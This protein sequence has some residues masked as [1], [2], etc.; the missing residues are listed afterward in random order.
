[1]E[2]QKVLVAEDDMHD[3]LFF[4]EALKKVSSSFKVTRAKNGL[5][6]INLLKAPEKPDVIFLDLTM[7]AKNGLD[8]LRFIK[9]AEALHNIPVI[10]YSTSHYIKNIDEAFKNDAHYYI[11][12]SVNE[13]LLVE[14]LHTVFNKLTNSLEK[15][16]IQNFVVR[17]VASIGS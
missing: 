3:F 17:V 6:C 5:E 11:I 7:P 4:K 14:L 16:T 2:Y 12:K 15:P 1:M 10:I 8:C 13:D 9:N